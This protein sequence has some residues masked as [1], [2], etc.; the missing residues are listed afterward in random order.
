MEISE[1]IGLGYVIFASLSAQLPHVLFRHYPKMT[2][3]EL[4]EE[5]PKLAWLHLG[6]P[7]L[8]V[9]WFVAFGGIPLFIAIV[10]T[11]FSAAESFQSTF[12]ILGAAIGSIS[13]LHGG[14][15]LS[16]RVCP[17]PRKRS[18]LYVYDDEIQ[19]NALLIL[20]MGIFVVMIAIA[21]IL[22]YVL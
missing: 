3:S 2:G 19:T 8:S 7:I 20:A 21:M 18:R 6:Y 22:F 1:I 12:Y 10:F 11:P 5:Y 17:L 15:A 9:V 13:V 16:T 14:L 4:A